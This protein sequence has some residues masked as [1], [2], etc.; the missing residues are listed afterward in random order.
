VVGSDAYPLGNASQVDCELRP[1]LFLRLLRIPIERR[2]N[3]LPYSI[4]TGEDA[5][6][7]S[8]YPR[9]MGEKE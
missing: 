4:G 9:S 6:K 5:N 7:D 8:L 1:D 2:I 3:R